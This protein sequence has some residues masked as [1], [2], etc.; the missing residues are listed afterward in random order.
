MEHYKSQGTMPVI[1]SY[2]I[3]FFNA[4]KGLIAADTNICTCVQFL[5]VVSDDVETVVFGL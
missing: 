1:D 3:Y 2:S 5:T 4:S